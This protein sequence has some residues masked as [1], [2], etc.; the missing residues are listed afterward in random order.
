MWKWLWNQVM[1]RSWKSFEAHNRKSLDCLKKTI[2]INTNVK[3]N[4]GE[5]SE[6]KEG[7]FRKSIENA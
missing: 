2:G 3:G 5:Q 1:G 4:S 6:R 7:N